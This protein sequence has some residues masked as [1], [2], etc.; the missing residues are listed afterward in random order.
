[1]SQTVFERYGGFAKVRK[2]VST[3]HDYVLDDEV[4]APYFTG[5]TITCN[6]C[7]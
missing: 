4:M 3:F 5:V 6:A 2:V 7:T 1:M